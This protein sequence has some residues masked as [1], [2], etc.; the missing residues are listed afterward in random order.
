MSGGVAAHAAFNGSG[1]QGLAV[2]NKIDG[3]EGDVMSVFWNSTDTT[4]QLL[5]G[6]SII[7]IPASGSGGS[8]SSNGSQIFTVN[9]D[10]DALGDLYLQISTNTV[11]TPAGSGFDSLFLLDAI[12]RIE[13][14]VGTQVWQTLH[15]HDIRGINSTEMSEDAFKDFIVAMSGGLTASGSRNDLISGPITVDPSASVA[16]VTSDLTAQEQLRAG[17]GG[18]IGVHYVNS[19]V[20]DNNGNA[21]SSSTDTS[22]SAVLRI[23]GLTRSVGPKFAKFNDINEQAYLLAGAPHQSVKI[24]V[25]MG[26]LPTNMPSTTKF[27][28]KLFGQCMVMSNEERRQIRSMP[29]GLPKRIKLSQNNTH[30]VDIP[31]TDVSTT[32]TVNIDLDHFS[33]FA[34]HLVISLNLTSKKDPGSDAN[35]LRTI[36]HGAVPVI[37]VLSAELKLNSS[38]YSGE[39]EGA[40]LTGPVPDSLGL[41]HNGFYV[42]GANRGQQYYVFPLAAHAYGGSSVP[43]N[44]FD[45]I[46]LTLQLE[47]VSAAAT[48]DTTKLTINTTCVGETTALYK[49]GAASLAMF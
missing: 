11:A 10:V 30:I 41:Y 12:R 34:S 33:L 49:H 45:N 47:H 23:P 9:N 18:S 15:S 7:E 14:V 17:V 48:S 5:H 6:S 21:V 8:L 13:I 35:S 25:Y 19:V 1:T 46:R 37:S 32:K 20:G 38:S 44:R 16:V 43:L 4:R 2:T 29:S 22:F 40:M 24:R 42:H 39:L 27:D 36:P 31:D 26:S 28:L 3:Q